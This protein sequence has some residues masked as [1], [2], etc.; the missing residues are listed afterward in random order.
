VFTL[1]PMHTSCQFQFRQQ[2]NTFSARVARMREIAK[3]IS[4]R[5]IARGAPMWFDPPV[6][7]SSLIHLYL[8]GSRQV[9]EG[10]SKV[11]RDKLGII[12]W[13]KLR[14]VPLYKVME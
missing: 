3:A 12:L 4:R 13:S 14:V 5:L 2:L 7:Q 1:A 9:L 10:V 6:P 8:P 11:L